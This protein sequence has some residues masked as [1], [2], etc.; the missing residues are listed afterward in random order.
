[1]NRKLNTIL[2]TSFGVI[3]LASTFIVGNVNNVYA[4]N[5]NIVML[6]NNKEL[7]KPTIQNKMGSFYETIES[8]NISPSEFSS[9]LTN[10]FGFDDNHTFELI[11]E[12]NDELGYTH[13]NFQHY[14]KGIP[15]ENDIVFLHIKE[16]KVQAVNGQVVSIGD[17]DANVSLS[18]AEVIAIAMEDFGTRENVQ[19]SEILTYISKIQKKD[20][21]VQ[22]TATKKI[23][24]I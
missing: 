19:Q 11:R 4:K 16:G 17:I 22:I 13:Q 10:W 8:Y 5:L 20:G 9:N 18:D 7:P 2:K 23:N 3:L 24:L 14:Y 12:Y 6:N 15:V 1:M 21:E